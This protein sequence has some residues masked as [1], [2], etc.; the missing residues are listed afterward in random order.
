M[1]GPPSPT[2]DDEAPNPM[3]HVRNGPNHNRTFTMRRKAAKH[4]FR[5]GPEE[6]NTTVPPQHD[7]GIQETKRPRLEE[8]FPAS[9]DEAI[10]KDTSH[11]T[12]IEL[13]PATTAAATNHKKN[14]LRWDE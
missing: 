11:D 6:I 14:K 5:W 10:T 12:T 1:Q 2:E 13:T 7:E 4:T 8:P 9:T 3:E